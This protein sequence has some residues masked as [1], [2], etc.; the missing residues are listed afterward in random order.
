MLHWTLDDC[1]LKINMVSLCIL[2]T[3]GFTIKYWLGHNEGN[4]WCFW[5]S[6]YLA[7][8]RMYLRA[9]RTDIIWYWGGRCHVKVYR[10]GIAIYFAKSIFYLRSSIYS[11]LVAFNDYWTVV[12]FFST[13]RFFHFTLKS[14]ICDKNLRMA[15]SRILSTRISAISRIVLKHHLYMKVCFN[16]CPIFLDYSPWDKS[17]LFKHII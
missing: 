6:K 7:V 1:L 15:I 11:A 4:F 16:R 3:I 5:P 10:W 2:F 9:N 13:L 14:G 8:S 17:F 12:V